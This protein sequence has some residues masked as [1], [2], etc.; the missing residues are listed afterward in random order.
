ME[1][2]KKA[3]IEPVHKEESVRLK[4]LFEKRAG[5]SQGA[6]GLEFG[7]GSQGMVWQYLNAR[8]PLNLEAAIKFAA[9]LR[10][11]IADF[12]PR[13]AEQLLPSSSS[14][15]KPKS[16]ESTHSNVE[17]APALG[18]ARRVPVVGTAQLGD[19]GY[20]AELESPVGFGDGFV[21]VAVRDES[22][23]ALRCRGDSMKP[24][25]KDGE[26]V[27]VEPNTPPSPGDEVLVK[28][29]DGRVMV[30]EL[31]FIRDGQVHLLSVN[32]THG[33]LTIPIEEIDC[34]HLV[35]GIIKRAMWRPD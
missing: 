34:M 13:L 16:A 23:Y 10:C 12:S 5:M 18:V 27:I 11:S 33:K 21:E 6:F 14:K 3:K 28:A 9:G 25:I 4:A 19:N 8:S 35:T 30:K 2:S 24:R 1:K 32:E 31:L 7:I 20:W 15:A 17:P 26:F 22:A 29:M